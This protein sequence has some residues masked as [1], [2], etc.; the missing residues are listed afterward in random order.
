M[1]KI[2]IAISLSILI[3]TILLIAQ[4]QAT[5]DQ[6][7]IKTD[8]NFSI[9]AASASQTGTVTGCLFS[10]CRLATDASGNLLVVVSVSGSTINATTGFQ[11]NGAAAAGNYLI[12]NGTNFVSL[13]PALNSAQPANQTGNGTATFKMNGLGAAAAP[14]TITPTATGRV[15]FFIS[16]TEVNGTIADGVSI[17]LAFGT[18][19]APANAAAASGTI[20]SATQTMTQAVAADPVGFA[21]Q[22]STTGLALATAVW[23]DLQVADVTGGTASI[24]SVTCTAHEM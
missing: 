12:G 13:V 9:V 5:P 22:G 14:C 1:K 6:L 15:L 20:I 19:T 4:T 16:G 8:S 17:K 18:G 7:R 11:V 24:T 23:F 2:L 21:I 10:N 3:G